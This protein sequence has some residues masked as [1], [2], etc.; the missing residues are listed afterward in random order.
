MSTR[1]E[2]DDLVAA[3]LRDTAPREAPAHLMDSLIARVS[4][5][6][7]RRR[8]ALGW[9]NSPVARLAVAAA[10][11]AAAVVA[12]IQFGGLLDR[13]IGADGSPS[14]SASI[15]PS[16]EPS[17]SAA[18]TPQPSGDASATP[19]AGDPSELVLRLESICD[20]SPPQS[21]PR[22][23]V[24]GDGTVIWYSL[25]DEARQIMTR[26]LT[27]DGLAELTDYLFSGGLFSV[28]AEYEPVQRPGTPE[29]PG[30]GVCLHTYTVDDGAIVVRST[31]WFGEPEEST[32]YEPAPER[33][34]LDQLAT[35]L[36]DPESL[37]ADDAWSGPA[38]EYEGTEYQL[39]LH[40]VRD[41]FIPSTGSPDASEVPWPFQV[42]L[43]QFGQAGIDETYRCGN[44]SRE[45]ALAIVDAIA[46]PDAEHPLVG[47]P[48]YASIEWAEGNGWAEVNMVPLMPDGYPQCDSPL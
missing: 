9:L 5:T 23:S 29:P 48:F 6:P 37:V 12:G 35:E 38:A 45:A 11:L 30:H 21:I 18:A 2:F 42:P 46:D 22:I 8:G 47:F 44:I 41:N 19:V 27:P 13:P 24:M 25:A 20:V 3:R 4:S 36:I 40:A 14:P 28:N 31:S 34:A 7:Q 43:D 1:D 15:Q 39:L 32:Y 33:Q 10:V 16:P 26:Q 17:D